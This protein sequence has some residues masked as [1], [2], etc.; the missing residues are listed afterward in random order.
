LDEIPREFLY[1]TFSKSSLST[2]GSHSFAFFFSFFLS[3]ERDKELM[4]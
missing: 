4:Q 3:S 1:V 2:A